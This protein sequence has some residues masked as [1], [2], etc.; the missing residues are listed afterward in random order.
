MEPTLYRPHGSLASFVEYFWTCDGSGSQS[1][2]AMQMFPTGVSGV[3]VQ[4]HDGRPALGA[5][6]DGDARGHRGCPTSF[7]FGKRTRLAQTF[8]N[9]PFALTGAVLKP[10]GIRTLLNTA[11]MSLSD[12]SV[13]LNE[14]AGENISDELLDAR[15]SHARVTI[16][17]R[18][19]AA[20][21]DGAAPEDLLVAESLHLI[22][23]AIHS[24]RVPALL[25]SLRVSE[26]QFQRRFVQAIGVT[27]HHYLRIVRFRKAMQLIRAGR[28]E[29]LSD[30]A[31]DLNY[32]DQSH[33]IREIEAF[34]GYTPKRLVQTMRESI[35][36][37]CALILPQL[38][39]SERAGGRA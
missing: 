21:V 34:S 1:I 7:V 30:V 31:Y 27:P 15:S 37:P 35:E 13:P 32:V 33:F 20:R 16:L 26:R 14:F 38:A 9:G 4:H 8:A 29:R 22:R 19:L 23:R 12:G 36:L 6:A 3:L 11:P 25:K 2:R 5:R 24:I 28:F 18:F 17:S 10:Q 39:T